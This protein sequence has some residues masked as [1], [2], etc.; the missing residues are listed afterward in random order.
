MTTDATNAQMVRDLVGISSDLKW[1]SVELSRI[2]DRLEAAGNSA[3]AQAI[4]RMIQ[5]FQDGE[6]RLALIANLVK[7]DAVGCPSEERHYVEL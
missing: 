6:K 5:V 4:L 1:S 2:T 3:D 7:S